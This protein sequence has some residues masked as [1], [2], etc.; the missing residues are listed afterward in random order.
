MPHAFPYSKLR[1]YEAQ[2]VAAGKPPIFI[3][4]TY[5]GKSRPVYWG[6]SLFLVNDKPTVT[7]DQWQYA[8]NVGDSRF[9]H[10]WINQYIE[11]L[12]T[13]YQ[14]FPSQGPSPYLWFQL[15]QCAFEYSLWGVL[16]D[17]GNYVAG[18]PWDA[19][20]PQNQAEY[21]T[22]IE[23]FFSQV[24]ALAPNVNLAA[25]IGSQADPTHFPQLFANVGGGLTENIYGWQAAP[26][27]YTR[28]SWYTQTFQYF[29]WLAS[30]GRMAVTRADLPPGDPNALLTSF[31]V[32]SL[33][34]GPN[35]FF[36][37]GYTTGINPAPSTWAGMRAQLG[38]P[39][40]GMTA[41][42]AMPA[43]T[44]Y[45]L[46][47]RNFEGGTV[48]LNWTGTTQTIALNTGLSYYDPRW[49]RRFHPIRSSWRMPAQPM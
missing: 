20:F 10:F 25:N 32:Y 1:A 19:P 21:E 15:D 12:V 24:K 3:T 49:Q 35:F 27:A 5:L 44:G 41:S 26:T 29:P 9:I 33:I 48:Y 17:N 31:V 43:G 6:W 39:L 16:D 34:K 28:N 18:V 11:P 8:V 30:Q 36:A 2:Q 42:A 37:P 46:F 23:T 14:V 13:T 7:P 22:G 38:S 45:R 4:A 40:S 47:S